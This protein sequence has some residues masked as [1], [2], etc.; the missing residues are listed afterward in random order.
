MTESE[1]ID[2][3]L[4]REA[5]FS[6]HPSDRGSF[7]NHGVTAKT[8]GA[9]RKLG[10]QATREEVRALKVEEA[11]TIYHHMYITGPGFDAIRYAPLRAQVI[12][13]GV[14]SGP[15]EATQTLQDVLGVPSDGVFGPR[16]RAAVAASDPIP[17]HVRFL[18]AR[19][20]RYAKIVRDNPSQADF[21]H[22]WVVRA[23]GFLGDDGR[24]RA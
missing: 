18:K 20:V 22:G 19:L 1:I 8:L 4:E 2:G 17:L 7:T 12:D 9:W 10:R 3:V 13:D 14:L 23:I 5:G 6:E 21:I 16:T 11:R 15:Y 24:P